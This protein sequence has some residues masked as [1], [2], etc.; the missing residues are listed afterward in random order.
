M[1]LGFVSRNKPEH[2]VLDRRREI[3]AIQ[4]QTP[5][6]YGRVIA[7]S[8]LRFGAPSASLLRGCAEGKVADRALQH[9]ACDQTGKP[10]QARVAAKGAFQ[11]AAW[12]GFTS[13]GGQ[14]L[15]PAA[16]PCLPCPGTPSVDIRARCLCSRP[17]GKR[18]WVRACAASAP[19]CEPSRPGRRW[20]P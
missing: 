1:R 14:S 17:T 3:S 18:L 12:A 2:G 19:G 13:G 20:K 7:A 6:C 4:A 11:G 10:A 8:W 9:G 16:A 5:A 15:T